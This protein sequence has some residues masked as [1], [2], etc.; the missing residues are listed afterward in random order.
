MM[1]LFIA[2]PLS[3]EV[4][5]YL[6]LI[7]EKIISQADK[8]KLVAKDQMHL[9]LKFLGEVQ[10]EKI[11][12]IRESLEKVKFESFYS[13]LVNLGIFP[14]EKTIK[15]VWVG[16]APEGKIF[17]LQKNVDAQLKE[18]F[19]REK[20]FKPHLTLARVKFIKDRNEFIQ[21]LKTMQIE[22]K[23]MEINS[24]RLV[25]STLTPQGSIYEPIG[26]FLA[27]KQNALNIHD[28]NLPI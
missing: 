17:F 7:Q 13:Y 14:S 22:S 25:K 19:K 2:I 20:N 23:N 6:A 15:V 3:E 1:R 18:L 9:T 27:S 16:L 28:P 11:D 26:E 10:P 5:E 21:R 4:K 12:K 8:L 24:F